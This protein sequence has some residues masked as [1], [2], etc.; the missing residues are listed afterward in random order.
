MWYVT[1]ISG[2]L[3]QKRLGPE[4]GQSC[5]PITAPSTGILLWKGH[6]S[7]TIIFLPTGALLYNNNSYHLLSTHCLPYDISGNLRLINFY[8]YASS[9][10]I[11]SY[12]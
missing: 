11:I 12:I 2:S 7:L 5:L 10:V 1:H 9:Y 8:A 3:L 4:G 6:L